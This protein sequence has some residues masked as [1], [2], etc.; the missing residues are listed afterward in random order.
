MAFEK[1][2]DSLGIKTWKI[3]GDWYTK[4]LYVRPPERYGPL[5]AWAWCTVDATSLGLGTL[6]PRE[7]REIAKALLEAADAAAEHNKQTGMDKEGT[8]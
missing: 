4:N 7:A 3:G 2:E 8:H 5:A 6:F 1:R